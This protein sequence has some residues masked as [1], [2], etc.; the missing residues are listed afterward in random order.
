MRTRKSR[1][2]SVLL[3]SVTAAGLLVGATVPAA[4]APAAPPEA[5]DASSWI[6][7]Q[8][9]EGVIRNVQFDFPDYGLTIDGYWAL[10]ATGAEP[11]TAEQMIR[12]VSANVRAY[13][14]FDGE[15]FAGAVAKALL[16]RKVAGRSGTVRSAR[17]DLR[18]QLR[19]MVAASGRVRDTGAD[20]FSSTLTQAL[21]VIAFGR[22][23]RTP[24]RVVDYLLAQQCGDGGFREAL[25]R[26]SCAATGSASA[27]DATAFAAQALRAARADGASVASARLDETGDWLVRAQRDNGGF[28]LGRGSTTNSN[29]TG[30][31]ATALVAL[32]RDARAERAGRYVRRLQLRADEPGAIA[33]DLQALREARADG[34]TRRTRDQWRRSTPQAQFALHPVP[35]GRLTA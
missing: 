4:A 19:S 17:L 22:S 15:F 35:L 27:V 34:I 12:A 32:G 13:V 5:D 26:R 31:A 18:G 7:T 33:Y 30:V 23:G 2:R 21:A 24:E 28:A 10:A 8:V 14:S 16:A 11:A 1:T 6:A 20:E 29:S 3:A 25:G 9:E